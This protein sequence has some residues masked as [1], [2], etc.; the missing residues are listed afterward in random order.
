MMLSE[1]DILEVFFKLIKGSELASMINGSVYRVPRPLNSE[2]E[3]VVISLLSADMGQIQRFSI[4]VNIYVPDIK[5]GKEFIYDEDRVRPLMRAGLNLLEH[6]HAAMTTNG[7]EYG[8]LYKLESQKLF[9]VKG[10]NFHAINHK[11][12]VEVSTE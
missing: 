9:E 5:R 3:D 12:E 8:I 2:K 7:K 4:N 6:G 10:T 11:I 1:I